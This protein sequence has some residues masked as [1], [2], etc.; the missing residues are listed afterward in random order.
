MS[1]ETAGSQTFAGLMIGVAM[2]LALASSGCQRSQASPQ[3]RAVL[4][5]AVDGLEWSVMRPLLLAGE[6]PHLRQL[7]ESGQVGSLQTL[8]PTHSPI[9][10]TSIATGRKPADH[11]IEGFV[12]RHE[13]ERR[14]YTSR[15]RRVKAF[16]NILSDR[17]RTVRTIGWW[18]TYP[19]E[20]VQG[21]MVSQVNVLGEG[22][23]PS[24]GLWKGGLIDD[25]PGQVYPPDYQDRVMD[26]SQRTERELDARLLSIF[27]DLQLEPG[28]LE[29]RLWEQSRWALRADLTYLAIVRDL[30][31]RHEPV[32]LTAVYLG[33]IDVLS[34]R[35]WRY[36]YPD[37]F[38]SPPTEEQQAALGEVL[39]DFMV[40]LDRQLGEI[41]DLAPTGINVMVLSDHGMQAINRRGR[42]PAAGPAAKTNSAHHRGA[43]PGVLVASGPGI[44][45]RPS[46]EE[47]PDDL[48]RVG[49]IYDVLP[50]LLTILGLPTAQ[51]HV[52]KPMASILITPEDGSMTPVSVAT[53]EEDHPLE[54]MPPPTESVESEQERLE[55]LKALGYLD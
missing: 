10:W 16:W 37:Q 28:S 4:L 12:Y 17:G 1:T 44:L 41:L 29:A 19:A 53:Y 13:G 9:I 31:A 51:D 49:S 43:P 35:F 50:T 39:S 6:L 47:L 23:Q 34:H 52:G 25:L 3:G 38:A 36:A 24:R 30:L 27:G 45:A 2:A 5:F 7:I 8:E 15:H 26:L 22:G 20:K 21:T 32:D 55:Q 54:E 46:S 18:T 42:F 48:T 11:G 14:L 33:G 40:F